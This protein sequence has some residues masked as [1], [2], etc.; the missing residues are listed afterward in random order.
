MDGMRKNCP[1]STALKYVGKKWSIEI[2]KDIFFGLKSFSEFLQANPKLS[3][4]VLSQRLKDLEKDEIITKDI[5]SKSP[6]K[7]EYNLTEKGKK[8]N[9][10]IY[11]LAV[12]AIQT[13]SNE[14]SKK[15]CSHESIENLK[16]A[17]EL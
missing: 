13:C 17:L 10:V 8:L 1:I 6:L 12:F 9:G 16:G 2:V 15:Q 5:V 4:K 3:G 14:L 11:E 7:I